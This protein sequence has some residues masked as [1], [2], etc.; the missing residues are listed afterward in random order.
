MR[1]V[2]VH[3]PRCVCPLIA[4]AD[5]LQEQAEW[6]RVCTHSTMLGFR[7]RFQVERGN[8]GTRFV[9][10]TG[11]GR[12]AVPQGL[13][14]ASVEE[15]HSLHVLCRWEALFANGEAGL[16]LLR[17]WDDEVCLGFLALAAVSG[18]PKVTRTEF[19][20]DAERLWVNWVSAERRL[21]NAVW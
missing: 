2:K 17:G 18:L 15:R 13:H 19:S 9:S 8:E 6:G 16:Q 5:R 4:H 3:T 21:K 7:G 20:L 14:E 1:S 10:F 12:G 11:D